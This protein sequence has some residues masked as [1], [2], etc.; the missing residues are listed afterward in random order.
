ML[1]Q[2]SSELGTGERKGDW[3]GSVRE[4]QIL[5]V[6]GFSEFDHATIEVWTSLEP[7][8]QLHKLF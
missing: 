3:P 4:G 6:Y 8:V 5:F 7:A 1:P 2:A